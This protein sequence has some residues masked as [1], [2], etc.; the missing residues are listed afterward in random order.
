MFGK[1]GSLNPN[2]GKKKIN[3]PET[4]QKIKNGLKNIDRSRENNPFY[5]KHHN[6]LTRKRLSETHKKTYQIVDLHGNIMIITDLKKFCNEYELNYGTARRISSTGK[7]SK[8][9]FKIMKV[10]G[11]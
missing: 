10:I 6:E 2:Y 9:G 11:Q 3:S 8:L 5:G 1:L 4:I 7:P